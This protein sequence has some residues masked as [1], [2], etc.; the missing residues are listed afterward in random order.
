MISNKS[1]SN[2]SFQY[3][4]DQKRISATYFMIWIF[5]GGSAFKRFELCKKD[6]GS[7]LEKT[8]GYL[9]DLVPHW[10][11]R[12]LNIRHPSIVYHWKYDVTK[13][14]LNQRQKTYLY[15]FTQPFAG[16]VHFSNA[17]SRSAKAHAAN[18]VVKFGEMV[19]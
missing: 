4:L 18:Y 9:S 16:Q 17:L 3:S 5:S 7:D 10:V 8:G 11:H 12:L 2:H 6:V 1:S 19:K 13:K 15:Q 14:S